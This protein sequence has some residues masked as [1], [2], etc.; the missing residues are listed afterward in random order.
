MDVVPSF[1]ELVQTLSGVMTRPTFAAFLTLLTGWVFTRRRTVTGMLQAAGVVGKRHH[2]AYHRVFAT[3]QW[4]LDALGLA[5]FRLL[6]PWL[7]PGTV[8]L[9]VDD[10]L[11]RKRGT[12]MY[13]VGMHHDPLASSRKH[14]VVS[15]GH[16]W[17][18]LGVLVPFPFRADH[19]FCLPVLCRLYRSQQ[20]H[21][22]E[23]GRYRTRPELAVELLQVLAEAF[24]ARAFHVVADAAYGGHQVVQALPRNC[25]LTSR[26]HL[27]AR[28][29][30]VPPARR[31]GTKGRTRVRGERL[32][33]PRQMLTQR[34]QRL[35]LQLYGYTDRS[36]VVTAVARLYAVPGRPVTVVA[37]EPLRGGRPLQ[38]F[39]A[40]VAEATATDVLTWYARRWA[41][42][43]TFHDSKQQLGFEQPQNWTRQA[44]ERTAP[45]ALLL[46]SLIAVWFAQHGHATYRK[47]PRPWYRG[48]AGI[49]FTAILATLKRDSLQRIFTTL[50]D[51][52]HKKELLQPLVFAVAQ[53]A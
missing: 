27:D 4:S 22:R 40:T 8:F 10:T 30:A 3:A 20:T 25:D 28:L 37:V 42:E 18:V 12:T 36:R 1:R 19:W 21:A 6:V 47:P 9:A 34:A 24:P 49:G 35:Q 32:P 33:T 45:V 39:F 44:V 29:H 38:A 41:L 31:P 15:W 14:T 2:A 5:V 16:S 11:A 43:Q 53:A 51:T 26:L 13:G 48:K 46:Y 23:G 52:P 7:P 17:V 50:G